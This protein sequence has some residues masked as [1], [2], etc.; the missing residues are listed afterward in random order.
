MILKMK[1]KNIISILIF[2]LLTSCGDSEKKDTQEENP[3]PQKTKK[4][5]SAKAIENFK[6]RDYILSDDAKQELNN[7]P[8]YQELSAQIS[9]L[10]KADITFFTENKDTLKVFLDSLKVTVPP[11]INT[12]PVSARISVLETKLL[13]LN[14]DLT[15]GNYSAENK[16]TSIK[17]LLIANSNLIYV[18]NKKLEFDKNDIGRPE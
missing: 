16:L 12:N 6:Y 11:I 7:W 1:I 5:I 4:S 17:D 13:K 8:M 14:N 10:K 18:I 9:F 2:V 15:L 3:K